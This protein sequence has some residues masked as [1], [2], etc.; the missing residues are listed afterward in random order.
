MGTDDIKVTTSLEQG[1]RKM[2]SKASSRGRFNLSTT[3]SPDEAVSW[4]AQSKPNH[5]F[6]ERGLSPFPH[7]F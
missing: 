4:R 3:S 1:E 7:M 5:S 2:L 6:T